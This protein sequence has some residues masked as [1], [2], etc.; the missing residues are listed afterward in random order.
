MKNIQ[1]IGNEIHIIENFI[2]ED[3][4]RFISR[5]IDPYV[6]QA[7]DPSVFGGPS[8]SDGRLQPNGAPSPSPA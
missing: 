2:S 5:S 1:T 4:A 8:A 7:P 3:T 6:V